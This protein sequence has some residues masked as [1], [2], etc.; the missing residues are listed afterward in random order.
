MKTPWHIWVVGVLSLL[1]NAGGAYDYLMTQLVNEDY[2]SMLTE[3]QRTMMDS[4]PLWFDATWALGVWGSVL[5]SLLI[6]LRSKHAVTAFAVSLFGLIASSVWSYGLAEPSAWE[7]VG[8]FGAV[9]SL[10]I[11]IVLV[12]LFLYSRAMARRAILN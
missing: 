6:L 9:F 11:C 3:A 4:R 12:M 10:A 1:W 8:S 2:L 7:V 5:G